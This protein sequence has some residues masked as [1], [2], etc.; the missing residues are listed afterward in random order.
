MYFAELYGKLFYCLDTMFCYLE[1]KVKATRARKE[2]R[3]RL[4]SDWSPRWVSLLSAYDAGSTPPSDRQ[5][6]TCRSP[7]PTNGDVTCS[8]CIPQH[9]VPI[10]AGAQKCTFS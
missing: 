5:A 2:C 6:F 1:K 4:S 7:Q 8:I 3:Q 9:P 10:S